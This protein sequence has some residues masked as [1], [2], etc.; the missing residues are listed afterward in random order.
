V[1]VS[2][3]IQELET[4]AMQVRGYAVPFAQQRGIA[5]LNMAGGLL[6]PAQCVIGPG[7]ISGSC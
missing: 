5:C 6:F 7:S 4:R 1:D 2:N 3:Q